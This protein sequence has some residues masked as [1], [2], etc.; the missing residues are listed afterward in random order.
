M[1]LPN[2]STPRPAL[3]VATATPAR[4]PGPVTHPAP[5]PATRAGASALPRPTRPALAGVRTAPRSELKPRASAKPTTRKPLLATRSAG[6]LPPRAEQIATR[7]DS[8]AVP[9]VAA[10]VVAVVAVAPIPV[11]AA[12]PLRPLAQLART[13]T[14]APQTFTLNPAR[15]TVLRS[16]GGT[17]VQ[18]AAGAFALA[19]DTTAP[20]VGTVVL[21]LR[22]FATMPDIVLANLTTRA[23]DGKLLESGGALWLGAVTPDGRA[24]AL[25]TGR[26]LHIA[27]PV[28]GARRTAMRAFTAD[29]AAGRTTN[30]VTGAEELRWHP[31]T[32]NSTDVVRALPPQYAPGHARLEAVL[33]GQMGFSS[34]LARQLLGQMPSS[35]RRSLRKQWSETGKVLRYTKTLKQGLDVLSIPFDVA[36]NGTTTHWGT[37]TGYH[38]ILVNALQVVAP[39]LPGQWRAGSCSGRA[40]AM[41]AR[42]LLLCYD[43]GVMDVEV[44]CDPDDWAPCEGPARAQFVSDFER[45]FG[46]DPA[47]AEAS[48]VAARNRSPLADLIGGRYLLDAS[49]LGWVNCYRVADAASAPKITYALPTGAPD[50]DVRLVFRRARVVLAGVLH[51]SDAH[52]PGVPAREPVTVVA[53]R[54]DPQGQ[55]W[56][57]LQPAITGEPLPAALTYRPVSPAELRTA[58]AELEP[59]E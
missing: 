57:A 2:P 55:T 29:S 35:D 36:E 54:T 16:A 45:G 58:L 21:Q 52:F 44:R 43:D 38:A 42:L 27:V 23:A 33:R 18:V 7:P 47:D 19:A 56:L 37:A 13:S 11:V 31:T 1:V 41:H 17:L 53:L 20:F 3:A 6:G 51:G 49:R 24:C 30:L 40:A 39:S 50:A 14:P 4:R 26:D 22:E 5:T 28:R 48:A 8:V 9:V 10:P 12:Q 25:R 59:V 32:S 46:P 34:A 15:D